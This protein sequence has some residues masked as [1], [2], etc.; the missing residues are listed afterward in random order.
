L[1]RK[2]LVRQANDSET[3]EQ[4]NESGYEYFDSVHARRNSRRLKAEVLQDG[5]EFWGV[6]IG[7][8]LPI[9]LCCGWGVLDKIVPVGFHEYARWLLLAPVIATAYAIGT[10]FY[11]YWLK[12][13]WSMESD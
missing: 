8:I 13:K 7:I 2:G 3:I 1:E 11:I 12:F 6:V 5:I 10:R 4:N 9:L